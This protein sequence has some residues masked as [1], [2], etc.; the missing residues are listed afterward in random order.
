MIAGEC[1]VHVQFPHE[2][3]LL[4]KMIPHNADDAKN[5]N[6]FC[7]YCDLSMDPGDI[8][9]ICERAGP[10]KVIFLNFEFFLNE[11]ILKNA[12]I[13]ISRLK[14]YHFIIFFDLM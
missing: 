3:S 1:D 12:I 2:S 8:A 7:Q 10:G 4:Q 9:V 11:D 5:Q 14:Y 13:F 6:F